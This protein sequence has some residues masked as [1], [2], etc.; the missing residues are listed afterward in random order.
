MVVNTN[1]TSLTQNGLRD[2]L[3]QRVSAIILGIYSIFILIF[4]A[5]THP[6]TFDAWHAL[7]HSGVVKAFTFIALISL[8]GHSWIG[9]WTVF[10]DYVKPYLLRVTLE[11]SLVIALLVY[12]AWGIVI[13]WGV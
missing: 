12:L 7:F 1:I 13:L 3:I 6:V 2:W 4:L 8:V 5:G 10:T 9:L 11:V